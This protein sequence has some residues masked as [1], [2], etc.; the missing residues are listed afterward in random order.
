MSADHALA[1]EPTQEPIV[2]GAEPAVVGPLL[3]EAMHDPRWV[4]CTVALI[5]G[6]KSNL[7]YR[8][9]SDAG[10]VIL[11]RPPLG[12]ILPTAHDMGRE[13]RVLTAL[14]GTAVPVPRTLLL[15]T[16]DGPLETPF[17]VMERVVGH[18][19]R[20]ELP[21]GYANTPA[22]RGAIGRGLIDVLA[23]L[24][25]I[26]P[27]EVGLADFGRPQGFME[28]QLRRWYEQWQRSKDDDLPALDSLRDD[29]GDTLPPQGQ[30]GIV[31]GDYRLDN[32]VLHPTRPGEIVAVLDWEMSTLGD[33]LADLGALLAYW[34]EEADDEVIIRARMFGPVTA[35]AGF[36]SRADLIERY[37]RQTGFDLSAISW[38]HA[39]AFFKLA[40]ICQGIAA[41]AAGGAMLG[42]GFDEAR[43]MVDP[44]V[45]AGR[46][47]LDRGGLLG[48]RAVATPAPSPEPH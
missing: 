9:R 44:L 15:G 45:Q 2:E 27:E 41:R 14:H 20:D 43:G 34:S 40:V 17:Y 38:Y 22:D 32:T 18:I 26:D 16:V 28:R 37:A 33:P 12:H 24:H 36:P 23:A 19:S 47:Q 7:T 1:N 30:P 39:F 46:R 8:V 3:A 42:S 31:H 29:L 48:K 35:A 13:Y 6:G 21:P 5:S 11:R 4:G 25:T 10:E